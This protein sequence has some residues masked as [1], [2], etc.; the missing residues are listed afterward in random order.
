MERGAGE[1]EEREEDV[2][3][4]LAN[5]KMGMKALGADQCDKKFIKCGRD[6]DLM[7]ILRKRDI[8]RYTCPTPHSTQQE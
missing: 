3:Q 2:K 1:G 8:V 6:N 5:L 4:S 7:C